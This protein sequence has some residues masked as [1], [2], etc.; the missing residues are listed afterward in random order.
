MSFFSNLLGVFTGAPAEPIPPNALL[1]DVRSHGE[2]ASGHIEG[3]LNVPLESVS[4]DFRRVSPD[5]LAP[6]VVYCRSGMRSSQA[7][8]ILRGM[9]YQQVINGGS[10]GSLAARMD[11]D[12]RCS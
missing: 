11:R 12:I 3:A 10:V 7:R 2:F 6:V 9:G 4:H 5:P 8:S 1:I